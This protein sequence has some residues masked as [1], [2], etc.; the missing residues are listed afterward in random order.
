[1]C[2]IVGWV[3]ASRDLSCEQP[4]LATMTDR[5]AA[6]GPDGRG[7]WVSPHALLGHRRLSVIDLTANGAQPMVFQRDGRTWVVVYNGEIYNH[8]ALRGELEAR[9]HHFRS[10]SDTEVLL[11]AYVE[12]GRACVDRLDGIFA[13]AIW[14]DKQ[15]ALFLARDPLG[16]KPLFWA[17]VGHGIVFASEIKALLAH[18][19]VPAEV[20]ERGL[21]ELVLTRPVF[22][23]T[24]GLTPFATIEELRGGRSLR[25]TCDQIREDTH[26][27]L[28]SAP[29]EHS[30]EATVE[31][32]KALLARIVRRQLASDVPV[33]CALSGGLD[34]SAITALAAP[35][36]RAQGSA[37]HTWCID[38][39]DSERFPK[40]AFIPSRDAPF[41]QEAAAHVGSEHHVVVMDTEAMTDHLLDAM[42][43]RDLPVALQIDT[44]LLLLMRKLKAQATVVLSG[45]GGDEIFAGYGWMA[46]HA[47]APSFPWVQR[48][49]HAPWPFYVRD[50]LVARA[51]PAE[52]VRQSYEEA[53]AE[54]P[55]LHGESA[56]DERHRVLSYLALRRWLPD[57]LD[58]NDRVSMAAGVEAR[59]PL[60]DKELVQY[61][62]NVPFAMK[63]VDGIEKGLF[64]RAVA[65]VLPPA[66][67]QRKK[68]A[69]PQFE[70]GAYYRSLGERVRDIFASSQSAVGELYDKPR[71]AA[72]CDGHV[73]PAGWL[74]A[75]PFAIVQLERV[76]MTDAWIREYGV[77]FR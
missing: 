1:M 37:L 40:H 36:L 72:L 70:H 6:R 20:D 9:G 12:W 75:A 71:I 46:P 28:H 68:S 27:R 24:P 43:A 38:L 19:G 42:R 2:G 67:V 58:R 4:L 7:E 17:R 74:F 59:V 14:D 50:D 60:C 29:H 76:V 57:L 18:P 44:S 54:V 61:L 56:A 63:H 39:V 11:H 48:P 69:F 26:W 22:P 23:S 51:R 53:L 5:L 33:A 15:Q 52:R 77:R 45:E 55:R 25:V 41:S 3:D 34:S 47:E 65:D 10:A 66:I 49:P 31:H 73:P 16:V 21:T 32:V 13:F 64:R 35:L 62:W 30:L 8:R